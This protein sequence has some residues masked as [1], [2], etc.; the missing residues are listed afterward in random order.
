MF[1]L[2]AL[3]ID[4]LQAAISWGIAAITAFPGTVGGGALGCLAGNQ[5][6]GQIGCWVG[7]LTVG[8]FGSAANPFLAP[9]SIPVG[10]AI[11]IAVA[12]CISI[13]F[14]WGF[15]VPLMFFSGLR[16]GRR[17]AWGLGEMIPGINNAPFWSITTV[18]AIW[19]RGIQ[20]GVQ[21][22]KQK[23]TST[24]FVP[25]APERPVVSDIRPRASDNQPY[26]QAT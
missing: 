4:G 21:I 7:G 23:T 8:I 1:I 18:V 12:M 11:G 26:A 10:I 2:I 15:L 19:K 20:K 17:L 25:Q 24:S 14:G 9:V 13:V 6:A 22:R 16:P 3:F 5:I